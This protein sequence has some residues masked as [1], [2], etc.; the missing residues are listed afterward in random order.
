MSRSPGAPWG[1][2]NVSTLTQARVLRQERAAADEGSVVVACWGHLLR[3]PDT[4]EPLLPALAAIL[5]AVFARTALAQQPPAP[6]DGA[7]DV[8]VEPPLAPQDE[9]SA[10]T[11]PV[12]L[13][14]PPVSWPAE[15]L[16]RGREG[17]VVLELELDAEGR[18]LDA[19]VVESGGQ[20]F[21]QA[22]MDAILDFRFSPALDER[23]VAVP[24]RVHYRHQF[25]LD[26][27]A[28]VAVQGTVRAGGTRQ[29]L[30]GASVMAEALAAGALPDAGAL[31]PSGEEPRR[32][33]VQ[34][35]PDGLFELA[36]LDP[37]R[38]RVVAGAPGF[39]I[40]ELEVEVLAG[41]V[42]ELS[43]HL[44]PD[45]PWEAPEVGETIE[46]IGYR[47][48][49]EIT[50][51]RLDRSQVRVL[52]GTG[53][54]VIRAVQ[55]Q[56][57]VARTPFNSGTLLVR[58]MPA[59]SSAFNLGGVGIPIVFHFGGLSTAVNGDL[60]SEVVFLPGSY[61]VRYGRTMGGVVDL[62]PTSQPADHSTGYVSVDLFQA[63]A[64]H[65]QV[66]SP[67]TSITLSLR[68]SYLDTI[69]SPVVNTQD[70][71]TV[72]LPRYMDGQLRVIHRN[73]RGMVL[74]GMALGSDDRF[75]Y[76]QTDSDG[77]RTESRL[78][79]RFLKG[80]LSWTMP[81]GRGW[82]SDLA[83]MAGPE[84][85][86]AQYLSDEEAHEKAQREHLRL[87]LSRPVP[88]GG[89]IGWR[90]GVDLELSHEEYL[91][92][93]EDL[94]GF[95]LYADDEEGSAQVFLPGL[96]LEQVQQQGPVQVIPGL[97]L[98]WMRTDDD[99][100]AQIVDPRIRVRWELSPSTVLH[101]GAGQYSQFPLL[102]E[103]VD[104]GT[105][106]PELG[107]EH[108]IQVSA[109]ARHQILPPLSVE[110]TAY[111][112]ALSD[113]VVGHDD[114]FT[115]ELAP[116]PMAPY[117]TDAYANDGTGRVLGLE[118]LTRY[119]DPRWLAFAAITLSRST[120]IE[121]PGQARTLFE[122]DQ[123]ALVTLVGSHRL[124]RGW[125]VGGRARLTSGNPYTP[126]VNRIYDLDEQGWLPVFAE[127][128]VERM[129][130]WAGVD[131][132]VDK[133]WT[134]RLWALTLY[135]DIQNLTNRR[136]VELLNFSP[137]FATEIPVYGLPILP[138]F[139]LRGAW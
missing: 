50:E 41:E 51:R 109:G 130:A 13:S 46:V 67:R 107:P 137:D 21:D 110:V 34:S 35:G 47:L 76:D 94:D 119:E 22:I 61:G 139:G 73:D 28:R 11:P 71:Y 115:F 9:E 77:D 96:Y 124:A 25:R 106:D 98:D 69:L 90:L 89:V 29:A 75:T 85:L 92:Q 128:N 105:G 118:L 83:V 4:P 79:L 5:A 134:F 123:P 63:A 52:P 86:A 42:V 64:M 117:D 30:V 132:R 56:P 74:Q 18:V 49:P 54:D 36:D 26:V 38:W 112:S 12:L 120:R 70:D 8:P 114:R 15:E 27:V 80:W 138:T 136:N 88:E 126:V 101:A 122:Y 104:N 129:P 23:G 91:Y 121:R 31:T 97:R 59:D 60:L 81:L 1:D 68:R 44:S 17:A 40:E 6:A 100:Q 20:A 127:S 45:R 111:G 108:A 125:R 48:P 16:D 95:F 87:E 39:G 78:D 33:T 72:R 14:A 7:P 2:A 113:L 57:G 66:L 37:G 32:V 99:Y 116:P 84:Q 133:E 135:L 131:L 19:R 65:E 103:I 3:S 82:Q 43:F 62:L 53:G 24:A 55:T 58:G 93:V 102:R 10:W